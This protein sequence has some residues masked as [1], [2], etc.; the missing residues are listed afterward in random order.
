MEKPEEGK[1]QAPRFAGGPEIPQKHIALFISSLRKGGSERVLV[2]LA[3]YLTVQGWRVTMVT[4]YRGEVEYPLPEGVCRVF[5]EITEEEM[6]KSRIGN[7]FARLRKLRNI[8]KKERPDVILSFIGKNNIMALLTSVFLH[9]PV[10]VS[11]RGEPKEE[12]ASVPLRALSRVLFGKA[13]GVILQSERAK[14]FFPERVRKRAVVLKNPLNPD[15]VR[16]P[17]DGPREKEIVAVGRVDANKNHEMIIRAFAKTAEHFPEYRLTIYGDGALRKKLISLTEELGLSNR[18]SLPGSVSDVADRIWRAGLFVLSSYSEGMPNTLLEAMC[19]GL[20]VISTNCSGGGAAELIRDGENGRL[21]APGD[22][23]GLAAA[24]SE[25]MEHPE[26]AAA[27]GLAAAKL[28]E[29]Y[30]PDAVA[31]TWMA[32]LEGLM[33]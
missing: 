29:S 22:V 21:V 4:Q 8:W 12:Y 32:Y 7:F 17:F 30:R 9:I 15:F 23:D 33:R 31:H 19:M 20:P 25:Y 14:A 16:Q 27:F 13:A 26:Q 5:S 6:K 2:N 28:L 3:E 24:M 18:I 10:A 11:V 1:R